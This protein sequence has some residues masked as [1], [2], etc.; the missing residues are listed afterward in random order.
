MKHWRA[1][2]LAPLAVALVTVAAFLPTLGNGWVTW[3]DDKNFLENAHFRGVGAEQLAWM[4]GTF[5]VG[6]RLRRAVGG[7]QR[8][9]VRRP[10]A[11]GPARCRRQGRG[12]TV[13][14]VPGETVNMLMLP[15]QYEP[16]WLLRSLRGRH[17]Q[18]Q[19]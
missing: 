2:W 4:W 12:G 10:A 16:E 7:V 19:A 17:G 13:V 5:H 9:D 8:A 18:T 11:R 6:D 15:I 1:S 14:C 3:D